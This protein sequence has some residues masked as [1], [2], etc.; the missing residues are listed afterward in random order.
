M[1]R[2]LLAFM[3][4][5]AGAVGVEELRTAGNV[6]NL[7]LKTCLCSFKNYLNL[8]ICICLISLHVA[9]SCYGLVEPLWPELTCKKSLNE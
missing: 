4:R 8:F 1:G 3:P 6:E 5:A 2:Q 9:L 7:K